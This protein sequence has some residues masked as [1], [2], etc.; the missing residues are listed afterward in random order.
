M[1]VGLHGRSPGVKRQSLDE[2]RPPCGSGSSKGSY[3]TSLHVFA[4]FLILVLSI[5]GMWE[6]EFFLLG[7]IT[8]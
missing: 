7:T 8:K 5:A 6:M 4:L 3:N 1:D 2:S